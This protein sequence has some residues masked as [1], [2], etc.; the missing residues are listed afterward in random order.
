MAEKVPQHIA[1]VMDGNGRWAARQGLPRIEGHS[2]GVQA[3]KAVVACCL[4]NHISVLSLFAFSSENWQRPEPEVNFLMGLF[5]EA[6]RQEVT[7]LTQQGIRLRFSGDRSSLSKELQQEMREAER[8]TAKNQHLLLNIMVNYG[9]KWDITQACRAVARQ[10]STGQLSVDAISE[11]VLARHLSHAGIPDPDLLIR[12]SGEYRLSN[13][14]LW[15]SAYTEL[16][17]TEIL[18]PDFD[19]QEFMRAID[20]YRKRERR[21]GVLHETSAAERELCSDNA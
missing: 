15:Q 16:Y 3:V 17:F 9:G 21:F 19:E 11:S 18:W 10:V 6:L 2:A 5:L 13:F 12:T 7:E 20:S 8:Q 1:I 4:R 14:F